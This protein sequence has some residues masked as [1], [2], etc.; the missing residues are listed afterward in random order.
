MIRAMRHGA[1]LALAFA[2]GC[3]DNIRLTTSMN[4]VVTPTDGLTT[5]EGG[6]RATFTVALAE[7]PS[8]PVTI[9]VASGDT[10][11]G[12]VSP[13][14]ITLDATN[15]SI[16]VT[17]SVT[18]VDDDSDDGDQQFMV[19]LEARTEGAT[20]NAMVSLTNTDNDGAGVSVTPIGSLMTTES[21]GAAMF[22][23]VLDAMPSS[24]VTIALVSSTPV[25][26][27]VDP[28]MLTFTPA[29]WN[30]PQLVTVTGVDDNVADGARAY[31][32][33]LG[34]AQS[35]DA[36]Y[37]GLEID[38]VAL[39]NIDNDSPGVVVTPTLGLVTTEGGGTAEFTVVLASE[40]TADVTIALSSSDP[41]EGEPAPTTLTFTTLNWDA[42]QPVTVTGADDPLDDG[43]QSYTIVLAPATSTDSGYNGFDP[44]NVAVTNTDDEAPGYIVTPTSGLITSESG[45][46]DTFTVALLNAPTADVTITMVSE[47]PTEGTPSPTTLVFTPLDFGT[48]RTI[49]VTGA[50]DN[51]ADGNQPY[52][53]L[54]Q[55]ATSADPAYDGLDPPDV[56]A[57][58]TDNDTPGIT[59]RPVS[60]LLVSELG[61]T[62]TFTIVLNSE[63]TANVSIA[64]Q[65]SDLTEGTVSPTSV[66]FT[67]ANWDIPR[68]VTVTGVDDPIADG[69]QPFSIATFPAVSTDP[70]YNGINP[71]NVSAIN[72]D[73]D[74]SAVVVRSDPILEVSE[75]G[76]TAT[77]TMVL[78]TPPT[79]DVT[80]TVASSDAS[81]GTVAPLSVVFT[82]LDFGDRALT[83][84]G[85]ND[86]V[87][88]GD[89]LFQIVTA[90]C[91][92][93]DPSYN[94]VNP[95][96]VNA[97][98]L[99]ND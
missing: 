62:A 50:D 6:G 72:F 11:E 22:N 12:T 53:I 34:P 77:F 37:Q 31:A 43:D 30:A 7:S 71:R 93:T 42:P 44:D 52:R 91:T 27:V 69:N 36:V 66:V 82:P 38:D 54:L 33:R 21:G 88:D 47:D 65:S 87:D 57:T 5:T 35:T 89:Q 99:D 10:G 20:A 97:R 13:A 46:S 40:P 83:V 75:A 3:G 90:A 73:D 45:A 2:F 4:L 67:M 55:P 16:P 39:T 76:T 51:V 74:V 92:S 95:R 41:G 14:T 79:A 24:N 49:T 68:V 32:I 78:T 80:C 63:P 98:N 86:N 19:S 26:G 64:L 59:V 81:E 48:P 96:D 94:N 25:E 1:L 60:G 85:V 70:R 18:G 15:F 8:S 84:T 17:V 61:D 23:V 56:S 28:A 9:T 58:N 29:N